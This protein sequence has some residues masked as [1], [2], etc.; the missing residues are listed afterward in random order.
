MTGGGSVEYRNM[1][2]SDLKVSAIGFG[3][4]EMGGNQYGA[5]DDREEVQAV[6]R[7]IDL[8]VT[9][10]DTAAIYG[11]GHSEEVLGQ[12]LGSR[13][14]DVVLVTKGGMSWDTVGGPSRRDSTRQAILQGMEDSLRRLG[15]DDVDLFL[16]HWPDPNTP[17]EE[18]MAALNELLESGKTR[19]V[20]VSNFTSDMLERCRPLAPICANQVGY[21]LF[22][23]R[24]ERQMFPAAR[25]LGIGVMAYGSMAHG[26]L[27]GTF[28]AETRFVEWDWRSRGSAFGQAL[29]A[30]ENFPKNVAVADRLK[31]IAA[32]VG[33]TLPQLA[34]AWVLRHPAVSVA[35]T[36]IRT[37]A[38]IKAN[39]GA[40]DVQL[41]PADLQEI[42]QIMSGAAG[43]VEA[44]PA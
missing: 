15:T 32:R 30:P 28:T 34:I 2:S 41:S 26:L 1:G 21:N 27:T 37:P 39:V 11:Y 24:W 3:C 33:T 6:H 43:Q 38:E 4:W 42:D 35:L 10:F 5:V 7:A 9:L 8:G 29:F 14:K 20:G 17:F 36:G 23:R 22:D 31:T 25:E 18:T 13:R 19:Y 44:V 40:V 16:I 12:A